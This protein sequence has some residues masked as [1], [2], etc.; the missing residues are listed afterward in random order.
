MYFKHC[1]LL[2]EAVIVFWSVYS[3]FGA[4]KWLEMRTFISGD[5]FRGY[6]CAKNNS[7]DES[8]KL[9]THVALHGSTPTKLLQVVTVTLQIKIHSFPNS[10]KKNK[11]NLYWLIGYCPDYIIQNVFLSQITDYC[12]YSFKKQRFLYVV[13]L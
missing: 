12:I 5:K 4:I 2:S 3:I 11:F 7:F 9:W 8:K 1:C 10:E 13:L 6:R